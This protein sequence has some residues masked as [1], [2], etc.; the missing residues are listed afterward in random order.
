M[1]DLR[2]KRKRVKF[3][4]SVILNIKK[5]KLYFIK[6]RDHQQDTARKL[7]NIE[8]FMRSCFLLGKD[9]YLDLIGKNSK[10]YRLKDLRIG[11][12]E[13]ICYDLGFLLMNNG[14]LIL[15]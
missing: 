11:L 12:M 4:G 5:S 10:E 6:N 7:R 1:Y 2:S 8:E 9:E 15:K 3:N 14:L 13:T